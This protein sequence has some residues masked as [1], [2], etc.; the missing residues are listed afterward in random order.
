MTAQIP[1]ETLAANCNRFV[2]LTQ[3]RLLSDAYAERGQVV[4]GMARVPHQTLDAAMAEAQA[5]LAESAAPLPEGWVRPLAV[6]SAAIRGYWQDETPAGPGPFAG[7][8][9]AEAWIN[10]PGS[11]GR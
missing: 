6:V 10:G 5:L 3:V 8:D 9:W 2:V 4:P 1:V 7:A 11:E